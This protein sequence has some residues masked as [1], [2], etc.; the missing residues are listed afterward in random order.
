MARV[1]G[2]LAR[3][4]PDA[5]KELVIHDL[6]LREVSTILDI[7]TWG[8]YPL[9]NAK[10]DTFFFDHLV[11]VARFKLHPHDAGALGPVAPI[12]LRPDH[13]PHLRHL[14]L[15]NVYISKELISLLAKRSPTLE[16]VRLR[17]IMAAAE[18]MGN[19]SSG[20]WS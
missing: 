4:A 2:L 13:I 10:F 11:N 8:F 20:N 12:G 15:Q 6:V 18:Y 16:T 7:M 14:D 19:R 17:D 1:W 9:F 5:V 3:N